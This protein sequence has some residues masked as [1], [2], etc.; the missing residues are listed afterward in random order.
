VYYSFIETNSQGFH[1]MPTTTTW[2]SVNGLKQ[3][4]LEMVAT[5]ITP[6]STLVREQLIVMAATIMEN[7]TEAVNGLEVPLSVEVSQEN[8]R[9]VKMTI[10]YTAQDATKLASRMARRRRQLMQAAFA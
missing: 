7:A 6:G 3:E 1:I 10:F 4:V 2:R 8:E 9:A 5:D